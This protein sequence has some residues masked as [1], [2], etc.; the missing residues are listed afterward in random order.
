MSH[1]PITHIS[2]TVRGMESPRH[3]YA[4]DYEIN[5]ELGITRLYTFGMCILDVNCTEDNPQLFGRLIDA[6]FD[7]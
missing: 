4:F 3:R 1:T 6:F 5:F 2:H 7:D